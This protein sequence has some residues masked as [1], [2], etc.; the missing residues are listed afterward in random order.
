MLRMKGLG[1]LRVLRLGFCRRFRSLFDLSLGSTIKFGTFLLNSGL[2]S[3]SK[4]LWQAALKT[5]Q[6]N[7]VCPFLVSF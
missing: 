4:L 6:L 3:V 7:Y 5:F 1:D 2:Q